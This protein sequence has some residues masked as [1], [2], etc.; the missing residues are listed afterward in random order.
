MPPSGNSTEKA[1]EYYNWIFAEYFRSIPEKAW[2]LQWSGPIF[3]ALW[4]IVLTGFFFIFA[5]FFFGPVRGRGSRHR[6]ELY[7]VVQFNGSLSERVGRISWFSWLVWLSIVAYAAY[8]WIDHMVNG[9]V[10]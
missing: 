2:E 9:Q 1:L 7:A 8:F 10:Y 3:I 5:W 6:G 4:A